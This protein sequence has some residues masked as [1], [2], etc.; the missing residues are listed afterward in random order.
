MYLSLA[1]GHRARA[2]ELAGV[3]RRTFLRAMRSYRVR[4]PRSD[5]K[6]NATE[7]Q[8]ARSICAHG[9]EPARA[10]K[11]CGVHVDTIRKALRQ[12]TWHRIF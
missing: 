10:A 12:E 9:L 2:A 5:A 8:W 11:H 4:W 3:S 1:D 6:L 7:V